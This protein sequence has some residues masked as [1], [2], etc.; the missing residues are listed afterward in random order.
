MKGMKPKMPAKPMGKPARSKP[1][2][3][4]SMG[5]SAPKKQMGKPKGRP[6]GSSHRY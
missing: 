1:M 5:R 4:P 6:T 3:K 2:G